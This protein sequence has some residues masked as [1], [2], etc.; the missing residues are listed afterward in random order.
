MTA[1]DP[2]PRAGSG[3]PGRPRLRAREFRQ[4]RDL[5]EAESGISLGPTKEALLVARLAP[6]LRALGLDAF[7][8]YLEIVSNDS[9]ERREMVERMCTHETAFFRERYQFD[10]LVERLVPRWRADASG[11]RRERTLRAW[12]AGCATGEEPYS[13]AMVLDDTLGRYEWDVRVTATD[14]SH[15]VLERARSGIYPIDQRDE[16]PAALLKR[17]FRRG[18][19]D[20]AGTMRTADRLNRLVSFRSLNLA[21]PPYD[22]PGPFDIICC[23]NVLIYFDLELKRRIVDAL[24]GCL[25][26]GGHLFLGH[27]EGLHDLPGRV[28][29]VIPTVYRAGV[30]S[31]PDRGVKPAA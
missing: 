28:R 27:A 25:A 29:A 9:R 13:I 7:D 23:R 24:L 3:E 8:R 1:S 4:L 26:P 6:R 15:A 16:I 11:G 12:S 17:Y 21:A 30:P 19:R 18:I 14:L 20:A 2:S 22:V 31:D 10:L 5:L